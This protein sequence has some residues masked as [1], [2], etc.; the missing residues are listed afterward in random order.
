MILLYYDNLFFIAEER[1]R[2]AKLRYFEIMMKTVCLRCWHL[3]DLNSNS[4]EPVFPSQKLKGIIAKHFLQHFS[5]FTQ[6][7]K[8]QRWKQKQNF[9]QEFIH[10]CFFI[11]KLQWTL[12]ISNSQGPTNFFEIEKIAVKINI[13]T[14]KARKVNRGLL[15]MY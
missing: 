8:G 10:A 6:I 14:N 7:W 5:H 12:S 4:K 13:F 11:R 15:G 1:K 9:L 2:K 3:I